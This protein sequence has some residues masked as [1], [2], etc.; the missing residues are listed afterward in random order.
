MNP[1]QT[2]GAAENLLPQFGQHDWTVHHK[3]AYLFRSLVRVGDSD[4]EWVCTSVYCDG[5]LERKP[6]NFS[7]AA[8]MLGTGIMSNSVIKSRREPL[9]PM[10][11]VLRPEMEA[12]LTVPSLTLG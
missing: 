3:T 6:M 10:V 1:E 2:L 12:R 11:T 7:Q 8:I 5:G 4:S 9:P